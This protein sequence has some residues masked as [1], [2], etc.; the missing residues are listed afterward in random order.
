MAC[1]K[2]SVNKAER[3]SSALIACTG[4]GVTDPVCRSRWIHLFIGWSSD[5]N[6][7]LLNPVMA[8]SGKDRHP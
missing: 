7:Y 5:Q 8:G 3:H 6:S 1:A 4:D 2:A